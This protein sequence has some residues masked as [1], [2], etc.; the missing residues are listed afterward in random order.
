MADNTNGNSPARLNLCCN[1]LA[2]LVLV[3]WNHQF[4]S[5][6]GDLQGRNGIRIYHLIFLHSQSP[7]LD[8][9]KAFPYLAG[10]WKTKEETRELCL[11]PGLTQLGALLR[12]A[13]G[14]TSFSRKWNQSQNF[15]IGGPSK[16]WPWM[17][18]NFLSF[19]PLAPAGIRAIVFPHCDSTLT[20]GFRQY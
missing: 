20:P 4:S 7:C 3:T 2:N 16:G 17:T 11:P 19:W 8:N 5:Q 13:A 6:G 14:P 18:L 12:A 1:V 15:S 10:P 9:P